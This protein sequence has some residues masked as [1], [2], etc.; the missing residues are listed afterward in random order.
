MDLEGKIERPGNGKLLS[1]SRNWTYIN[2]FDFSLSFSDPFDIQ[3]FIFHSGLILS[4]IK[5]FESQLGSPTYVIGQFC[6]RMCCCSAIFLA[7]DMLLSLL[8]YYATCNWYFLYFWYYCLWLIAEWDRTSL[9][10]SVTFF[11]SSFLQPL[12]KSCKE[13][14]ESSHS[15]KLQQS[16]NTLSW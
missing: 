6:V 3:G 4:G 1:F 12:L 16:K 5:I 11:R 13:E 10:E 8:S 2:M 9:G 14:I 7:H 15:T